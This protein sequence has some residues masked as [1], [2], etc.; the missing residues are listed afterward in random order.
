MARVLLTADLV[1]WCWCR[2][3][4]L[5]TPPLFFWKQ[6]IL[7]K[8]DTHYGPTKRTSRRFFFDDRRLQVGCAR[9]SHTQILPIIIATTKM[10][11]TELLLPFLS[12]KSYYFAGRKN[13]TLLVGWMDEVRKKDPFFKDWLALV[14]L[15]VVAH[16][17]DFWLY[18]FGAG[19]E[20]ESCGASRQNNTARENQ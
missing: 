17:L 16:Q 11:G 5:P 15:W 18:Y 9:T 3:F 1:D 13:Q 7:K 8:K 4:L 6:S 19:E 2:G 14:V 12:E 20:S 10:T